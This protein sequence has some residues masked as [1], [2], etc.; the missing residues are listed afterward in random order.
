MNTSQRRQGRKYTADTI[1]AVFDDYRRSVFPEKPEP[2]STSKAPTYRELADETYSRISTGW[3]AKKTH[4][5]WHQRHRR[6]ILP[7]IGSTPIDE[8]E[9]DDIEGLLIPIRDAHPR[10]GPAGRAVRIEGFL[11]RDLPQARQ[12]Q[13]RR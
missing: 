12:G 11:V 13:Y 6:Y 3:K 1:N 2:A 10:H 7:A 4:D 5:N 9:I 8:I